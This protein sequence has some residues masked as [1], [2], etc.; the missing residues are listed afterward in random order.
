MY[1]AETYGRIIISE[2]C[3]PEHEK[4]IKPTSIGG[5][6]GGRKYICHGIL[7]KFAVDD[8]GLYQGDDNAM[9]AASHDLKG[10]MNYYHCAIADLHVPLMAYID[11]RGFRLTAISVLPLSAGSL[12]YGSNDVGRTVHSS[13]AR[14]N[15]M[16][17]EAGR[18]LNLKGHRVGPDETLVYGPADIE[19]HIGSDGRFYVLD[20]ARVA[21]PQPPVG[22]G[23]QLFKLFR[24]EFVRRYRVPL[25][26]DGFSTLGRI[27]YHEHNAEL[28]EAYEHLMGHGTHSLSSLIHSFI[29]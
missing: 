6:A 1:C 22:R 9:K 17:Q 28:R 2:N 8:H 18:I 3:L 5:V 24:M 19:G 15:D 13:N 21:P 25:C 11:Y 16:M 23:D 14:L 20:F 10:L 12:A 29:H 26:S 27:D 7:F 4:T